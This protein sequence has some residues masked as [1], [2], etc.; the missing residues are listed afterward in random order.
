MPSLPDWAFYPTAAAVVA[1][2]IAAATSFG[3]TNHRTPEEI[4][5][6]GIT[7]SGDRLPMLTTG[8]GL[9]VEFLSEDGI[10]FARI[11]AARGPLD[12][13]QSAGA[14]FTLSEDEIEALEGHRLRMTYVVRSSAEDGA[15]QMLTNLFI[16]GRS[17]SQ[18][19]TNALEPDFTALTVEISPTRCD[20]EYAY[21][22]VWPDWNNVRNQVDLQ[23]VD[24][25]V[26]EPISC[27]D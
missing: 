13:I 9:T 23:R 17:Q 6:E 21:V 14:F 5:A 11:M 3:D 24:V 7:F 19:E 2:M 10:Q 1:A 20:W 8:N 15:E 18:W 26:L 27:P 25:T 12:G 4:R 22:S 16:P